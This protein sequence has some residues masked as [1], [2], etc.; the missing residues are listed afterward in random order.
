VLFAGCATGPSGGLGRVV[1]IE[2]EADGSPFQA[3]HAHLSSLDPELAAQL[4]ASG[5]Q[6]VEL[7][8]DRPIG[9]FGSSVTAPDG[10]CDGT[11]EGPARLSVAL[12]RDA[13]VD[14]SGTISG[15]TPVQPW[16]FVGAT[17]YEPLPWWGGPMVAIDVEEASGAPE[18]EWA[19]AATPDR[20][21]VTFGDPVELAVRVR[22]RA[23]LREVRFLAAY[24]DWPARRALRRFPGLDPDTTWRVLAICRAPGVAG[25]PRS[26]EGC[27]WRGDAQ[28]AT[29]SFSWDPTEGERR[30]LVA[31]QPP[32]R[33]AVTERSEECVPVTF[34][35]DVHDASGYRLVRERVR[36]ADACDARGPRLGRSVSLDPPSEPQ[37]PRQA[38]LVCTADSLF[39]CVGYRLVW[40]DVSANEQGYRIYARDILV[41]REGSGT[42]SRR[43][44]P[45]LLAT[46]RADVERWDAA[47]ATTIIER[48]LPEAYHA[49]DYRLS[50]SAY[51]EFG[52]SGQ[53]LAP[54]RV[55]GYVDVAPC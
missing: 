14:A 27:R 15:G 29:V 32:A 25:Q 2:R 38:R 51:N 54:G 1:V 10:T 5:G 20:S 50:V 12:L 41:C 44:G 11:D 48:R 43:S 34:A 23:D 53:V 7:D 30:S 37:A 47:D 19:S 22:D 46:V 36:I 6:P 16:P 28:A 26:T 45:W 31:W 4:E 52:E 40:N 21:H 18:G 3:V 35:F 13:L 42:S 49:L 8:A 9:T 55:A 24:P 33:A 39:G 17:A